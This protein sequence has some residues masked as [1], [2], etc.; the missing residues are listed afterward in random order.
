VVNLPVANRIIENAGHLIRL[1]ADDHRVHADP[2]TSGSRASV[3]R[4]G[5]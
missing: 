2:A 5:L 3:I 1:E 4:R